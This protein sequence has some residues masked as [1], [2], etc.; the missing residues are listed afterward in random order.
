MAQRVDLQMRF[1]DLLGPAVMVKFQPPPSYK[2]CYPALIYE[3]SNGKTTFA[4]NWPYTFERKYSVVYIT[5]D[6]DDVN[7]KRIA[8]SFPKCVMD[9]SYIADNLNHYVFTLF[10]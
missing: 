10:Y 3:Q 1:K 5:R 9:R 6:P 7:V 2:L 8:T 4:D